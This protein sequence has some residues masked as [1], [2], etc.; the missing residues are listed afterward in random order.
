M[1][2]VN[3]ITIAN[4]KAW[5]G[6]VETVNSIIENNKVEEFDL[7]MEEIYP[8]GLTNTELN[9]ILWFETDWLYETLGIEVEEE[10]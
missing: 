6:A 2:I 4:F 8:E 5:E 10:E 7:L 9:D 3:E 1:K